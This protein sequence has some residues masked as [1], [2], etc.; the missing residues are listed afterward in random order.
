ML[1]IAGIV[2]FLLLQLSFVQK[3]YYIPKLLSVSWI[4]ISYKIYLENT[5]FDDILNNKLN[6]VSGVIALLTGFMLFINVNNLFSLKQSI[7]N[8]SLFS[9][10]KALIN[11]ILFNYSFNAFDVEKISSF[12]FITDSTFQTM[13]NYIFISF[14]TLPLLLNYFVKKRLFK[15]PFVLYPSP[16]SLSTLTIFFCFFRNSF[17]DNKYIFILEVF[18]YLFTILNI[19]SDYVV[20]NVFTYEHIFFIA[21][22]VFNLLFIYFNSQST[23]S[24]IPILIY[25]I[26]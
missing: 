2:I 8:N 3:K 20:W 4:V 24:N 18:C 25:V 9:N 12:N 6:V 7:M 15:I 10:L 16:I 5:Y 14:N 11:L 26:Y 22:N 13:L 23:L 19:I 21:L 17:I 1:G